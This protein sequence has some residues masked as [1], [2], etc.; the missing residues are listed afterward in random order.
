MTIDSSE[1]NRLLTAELIKAGIDRAFTAG[2]HEDGSWAWHTPKDDTRQGRTPL[3][4]VDVGS[5]CRPSPIAGVYQNFQF[6]KF[7]IACLDRDTFLGLE[8]T[9]AGDWEAF[10]GSV[11]TSKAYIIEYASVRDY[12]EGTIFGY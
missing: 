3:A 10:F 1:E 5:G 2:V 9:S 8:L 12:S 11:R 6:E 7:K 4:G